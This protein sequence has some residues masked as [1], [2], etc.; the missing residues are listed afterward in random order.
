MEWKITVKQNQDCKDFKD[1]YIKTVFSFIMGNLEF[2]P[3]CFALQVWFDAG[4]RWEYW[5]TIFLVAICSGI[6][7]AYNKNCR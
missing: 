7:T 3:L 5:V 1:V 4:N 2:I 6:S